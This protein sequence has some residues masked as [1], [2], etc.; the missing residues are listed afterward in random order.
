MGLA[1]YRGAPFW[2]RK[3][4]PLIY[5][6]DCAWHGLCSGIAQSG[7]VD[8]NCVIRG[9]AKNDEEVNSNENGSGNHQAL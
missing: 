6:G 4:K 9:P 3:Y 7:L 8:S 2:R 5:N 1:P